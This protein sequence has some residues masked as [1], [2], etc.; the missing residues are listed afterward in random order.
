M[1]GHAEDDPLVSVLGR[2]VGHRVC[3][4]DHYL[5]YP[6]HLILHCRYRDELYGYHLR[7][8]GG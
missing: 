1:V 3:R 7:G 2:E 5:S 6:D 8:Q 4:F